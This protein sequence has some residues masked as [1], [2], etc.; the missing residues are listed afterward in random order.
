M[1]KVS[2]AI[3]SL[4]ARPRSVSVAEFQR[5][6]DDLQ[7]TTRLGKS[8]KHMTYVHAGLAAD[9]FYTGS[10]NAKHDPVLIC[11]VKDLL[12]VLTNHKAKLL[13][14]HGETDE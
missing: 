11:Y 14:I 5:V 8:G 2:D 13:E 4:E 6:L 10:F 12:K 9:G 7:F 3:A 1:G